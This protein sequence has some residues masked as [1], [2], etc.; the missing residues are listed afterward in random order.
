MEVVVAAAQRSRPSAHSVPPASS[1][2]VNDPEREMTDS[3]SLPPR[4]ALEDLLSK[5]DFVS[6]HVPLTPETDGMIGTR[7]LALMKPS[8]VVVNSARGGVVDERG[9]FSLGF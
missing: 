9:K 4:I 1:Y 8:A 5:S 3:P 6:L 7:E 2:N